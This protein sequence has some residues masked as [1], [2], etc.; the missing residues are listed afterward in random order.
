MEVRVLYQK[1]QS[2]DLMPIMVDKDGKQKKS[3]G[4]DESYLMNGT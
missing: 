4:C 3:R 1:I 2:D